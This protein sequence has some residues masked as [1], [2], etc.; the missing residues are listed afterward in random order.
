M[1]VSL[2]SLTVGLLLDDLLHRLILSGQLREFGDWGPLTLYEFVGTEGTPPSGL[3][4]SGLLPW[5]TSD[6]LSVRFFRPLTSALLTLDTWLFGQAPF[7]A[8][9]HSL[10]W[11]LGM[12]T[13]VGWL[14]RRL[15]PAP[16]A[17]VAT[18]AYAVA[19]AHLMPVAWI[20]ARHP[21][22]S[23][24]LGLLAL[25]SWLRA[26]EDGWRPGRVLAVLLMAV[27]LLSGEP[28]LGAVALLGAYELFGRREG[29]RRAVLAL[30]PFVVLVGAYLAFY[31]SRRYG[32]RGSAAYLDPASEPVAFLGTVAERILI[33]LGELVAGTPSDAAS[34]VPPLHPAFA[35]WGAL[36]TV[37][38]LLL[39]RSVWSRLS[40]QERRTLRWLLPGGLA[41]AL[42]GAIGVIGGRVLMVPL[43]A[44]GALGAVLMVRGW[45]AAREPG[46]ARLA[47]GLLKVAVVGLV[48]G[49]FVVGPLF[50]MTAGFGLG[51]IADAQWRIA[52]EA[53]PCEGTLVMVAAAD[54]SVATYAPAAMLLQGRAPRRFLLLSAAPHD[55]SLERTSATGLDLVV[56]TDTRKLGFWEQM[57]RDVPP[58]PGAEVRME[59][60][61]VTVLDSNEVGPM[62]MHFEFDRPL[63]SPDLCFVT[64]RDGALHPLALPPPG[65]GVPVPHSPGPMRL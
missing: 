57:Y 56:R 46:R 12:V 3:R 22:I 20:A 5:W 45:E 48:L 10:A 59:G 25:A 36:V 2:P 43:L 15:L 32:A 55:H 44:G 23:G 13:V 50:R 27:A 49:Q 61:H 29:F 24:S 34:A 31:A 37:A 51:Q 52:R 19:A 26:R 35:A 6:G 38:A 21:L 39:L 42:P 62:R 11:F 30:V 16:Q 65:Q 8:H 4:E 28:A 40:E 7:P 14:H 60:L 64:W 41:A 33:L 17:G 18:V 47:R 9:L 63:E 1:L 53:P 54:P 58:A